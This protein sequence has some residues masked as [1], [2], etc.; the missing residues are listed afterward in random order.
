MTL[1]HAPITYRAC[2][3]CVGIMALTQEDIEQAS[4]LLITNERRLRIRDKQIARAGDNAA[5]EIVLEAED[6]RRKILI[7]KAVL[8]PE[9][10]DE[11][12]GLLKRRL[13]DDYFIFQQT[14]GAKQD[15]ALLR[16]DVA[17][18]KQAQSL[19]ATGRMQTDDRIGRIEDLVTTSESARK[20]GAKW[21]RLTLFATAVIGSSA[22][23]IAIAIAVYL[24]RRGGL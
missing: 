6:I 13:E 14:L 22:L 20:S 4:D 17:M 10:P 15:V 12:S 23:T 24:V 3:V 7:L 1:T 8:E 5:P 18:V 9:I 16:D 19:A 2:V 11:V 21:Y